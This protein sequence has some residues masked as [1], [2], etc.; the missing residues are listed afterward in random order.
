MIYF[1][2]LFVYSEPNSIEDLSDKQVM[3]VDSNNPWLSSLSSKTLLS[4]P[5]KPSLTSYTSPSSSLSL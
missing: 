4:H 2:N 1:A 3:F 5:Y